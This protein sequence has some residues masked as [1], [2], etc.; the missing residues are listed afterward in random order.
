MTMLE[1]ERFSFFNR[2]IVGKCFLA[3]FVFKRLEVNDVGAIQTSHGCK[4]HFELLKL[5]RNFMFVNFKSARKREG[6][7]KTSVFFFVFGFEQFLA[8]SDMCFF[9]IFGL[10]CPA[11]KY[12]RGL[13]RQPNP[14]KSASN[15]QQDKQSPPVDAA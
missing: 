14:G 15:L 5:L 4:S 1:W 12:V 6:V 10:I 11:C 3:L 2:I 13:A 9:S 8:Y 7:K